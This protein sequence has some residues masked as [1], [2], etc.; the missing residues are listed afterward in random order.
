MNSNAKRKGV[1]FIAAPPPNIDVLLMEG[2]NLDSDKPWIS[3]DELEARFI[4]LFKATPGRV[5]VSW[6]AQ[7]IDRTVTLYRSCLQS[8][9]TLVVD[10]YTA[11]VLDLLR[12]HGKLPQPDWQNIKVVV[13]R[14]FARMYRDKGREAFVER[15]AKH[16]IAARKLAETPSHWAVMIRE[17]LVRDFE[18]AGDSGKQSRARLIPPGQRPSTCLVIARTE[19][20]TRHSTQSV[21]S[22]HCCFPVH[23]D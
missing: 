1:R 21:Q 17:S 4:T 18:A 3:E 14:A 12:E 11:E 5:F 16:G 19:P 7:N 8:G 13:T 23:P 10:L 2:T 6:S 20:L 22:T 15:M 9:R